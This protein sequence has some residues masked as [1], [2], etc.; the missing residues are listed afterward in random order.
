[1]I[2]AEK[3]DVYAGRSE[4]LMT[5]VEEVT[6]KLVKSWHLDPSVYINVCSLRRFIMSK[7]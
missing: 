3:I 2:S 4:V 5:S 1:M 6:L 7:K